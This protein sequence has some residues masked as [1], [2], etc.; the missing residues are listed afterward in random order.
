MYYYDWTYLLLIPCMI[1]ALWAQLRVK[2]AFSRY[3]AVRSRSGLTGAEV[4]RR[5]LNA[6]GLYDVQV[7]ATPGELTDH[8]DPRDRVVRLSSSTYNSPSVA[9]L[10]VAAHEVG[11]ACQHA[12]DYAPLKWRN[13]IIPVTRVGSVLAMPLFLIGLMFG[14]FSLLG[15]TIGDALMLSGILLFSFS[16]LFQLLTLPTEF[17]ASRRAMQTL[18]SQGILAADELSG[19]RSVL[20]AAALTY[21][22]ALASSLVSLFRLLLIYN[23]NS[24]RR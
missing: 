6:N 2:S 4:A 13:A 23:N 20:N 9:A 12:N 3:N 24:R 22:A 15:G 7:V 8:Y 21:V 19:A 10:G 14:G 16:T 17:N 1:F 18:E 11:H 5:I